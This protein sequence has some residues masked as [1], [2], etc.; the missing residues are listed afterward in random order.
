M[1]MRKNM[2]KAVIHENFSHSDKEIVG[3]LENKDSEN[4][5]KDT[6]KCCFVFSHLLKRCEK[7]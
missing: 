6:L 3:I 4:A 1:V 5:K 7:H 2:A